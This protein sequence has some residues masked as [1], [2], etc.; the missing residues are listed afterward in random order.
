V[1]LDNSGNAMQA[2]LQGEARGTGSLN[3]LRSQ[4]GSV[5]GLVPFVSPPYGE[6]TVERPASN[7]VTC[8]GKPAG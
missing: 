2:S 5:L 6:E 4:D 1:G 7:F 8:A 3:A